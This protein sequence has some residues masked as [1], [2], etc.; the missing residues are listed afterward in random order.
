MAEAAAVNITKSIVIVY[1]CQLSYK[2]IFPLRR[3]V[4]FPFSLFTILGSCK[5]G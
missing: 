5:V 1:L 4:F 2:G 3:H